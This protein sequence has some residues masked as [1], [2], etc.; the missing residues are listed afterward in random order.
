V[1]VYCSHLSVDAPLS[2]APGFL[3]LCSA[4]GGVE[5]LIEVFALGGLPRI[6]SAHGF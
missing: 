3:S 2:P 1:L 5:V 4:P 6:L